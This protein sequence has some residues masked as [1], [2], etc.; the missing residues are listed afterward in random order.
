[1]SLSGGRDVT[2][3]NNYGAYQL[4]R[5]VVAALRNSVPALASHI[6]ADFPGFNPAQPDDPTTFALAVSPGRSQPAPRGN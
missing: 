5:A 6:V 3:H 1:M 4:A 2:H